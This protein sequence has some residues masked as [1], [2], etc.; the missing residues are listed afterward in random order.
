[1]P[2][3]V[4]HLTNLIEKSK[5]TPALTRKQE[6]A[7][8][9]I[10][11]AGKLSDKTLTPAGTDALQSLILSNIRLCFF[12]AKRYRQDSQQVMELVS[13][14]IVGLVDA[15]WKFDPT[16][17]YRFSTYAAW[18]IRAHMIQHLRQQNRIVHFPKHIHEQITKLLKAEAHL[19]QLL[20]RTPTDAELLSELKWKTEDLF[21]IRALR[22]AQSSLDA[23]LDEQGGELTMGDSLADTQAK[24]PVQAACESLDA[25]MLYAQIAKLDRREAYILTR[26]H[27][28]G[29][30]ETTLD[31]IGAELKISRERVRQ[32]EARAFEKLKSLVI[33]GTIE[34]K[35]A[36]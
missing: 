25:T 16:L 15:A 24:T 7:L 22:S 32:L 20:S 21:E 4:D 2:E 34:D 23:P 1:M 27:G 13:A 28:L 3:S 29:S 31:D 35:S 30:E 33:F 10:I 9:K 11:Q 14:G 6:L 8:G 12:Q 18:P 5:S 36:A 17:K 26:R 19:L